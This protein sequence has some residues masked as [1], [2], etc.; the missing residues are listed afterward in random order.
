MVSTGNLSWKWFQQETCPGNGNGFNRKLVL[1]MVSTGN[2]VLVMASTGNF[3][4]EM[5]S[6]G[7]FVLVMA[8]RRERVVVG[9]L[10]VRSMICGKSTSGKSAGEHHLQRVNMFTAAVKSAEVKWLWEVGR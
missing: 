9:T 1:E 4:L 5:V 8:R 3:V 2:F 10:S 6:T 7:N